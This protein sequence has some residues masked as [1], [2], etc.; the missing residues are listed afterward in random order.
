MTVQQTTGSTGPE[1]GCYKSVKNWVKYSRIVTRG[2][3]WERAMKNRSLAGK[4]VGG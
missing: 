3:N 2:G 1:T 4:F